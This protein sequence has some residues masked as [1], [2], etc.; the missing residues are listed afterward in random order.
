MSMPAEI[1]RP[2]VT[3]DQLLHGMA[4]V[5]AIQLTGISSDSRK[6]EKGNVFI[7]CQGKSTHGLDYLQQAGKAKIAAIVW[8]PATREAP[9]ADIPMFPVAGLAGHLG[10]IANRF[11]DTPSG[12]LKVSG[13]TG[14][15]GK[16]TVAYL[17]MQCLRL[18]GQK[19]GYVGT[20]G[21]GIDQI[22]SSDGMTT[23]ACIDLHRQLA[24]FCD[25]GAGHAAIEV[26]SHALEQNRVDGVHFDTAIFTNLSRDHIDYHGS[27]QAYG[28]TKARLF[29]DYDVKNRIVS[30]DSEFGQD[31]AERC[32]SNVV[33][34]STRFDRVA[35]GRPYVFVRAVVATERGSRVSVMS[36]WGAGEFLL[37]L[38]GDFNVANA[39]EVLAA[40]LCWNVPLDEACDVLG[41]VSAPPG[42]MQ[43][44]RLDTEAALPAVFVDYSHT[45]ASLE[46]AL[47][48]LRQHC[49]GQLWCVFGCGGDRDR[50][51]RA[52]MGKIA[53]RHADHAVVTNDN[54]RS[55]PP[56]EIIADIIEEMDDVAVVIEDRGAAIAHAVAA[57][58]KDDV[59][60]IAGKGHEDYQILGEQRL[61]FSD[62]NVARANLLTRLDKGASGQ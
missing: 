56:A 25:A 47:R 2:N 29:V 38:P 16:T 24:D 61:S 59:I 23:P 42:R 31:L 12:R 17:I 7:A 19:C 62:Y 28:E 8:D 43:G 48:A 33:T 6:L 18:L 49:K 1:L 50:G 30:L 9:L 40:M 5:P 26:S 32:G 14:T 53:A 20:L 3:L 13:V 39:V 11:F 15:N 41:K 46:A 37:P 54:P 21:I 45:P 60:L 10:A 27:M 44:V 4:E 52:L 55:E 35:N 34:V 22:S 36:S 57:A 51:K 58:D